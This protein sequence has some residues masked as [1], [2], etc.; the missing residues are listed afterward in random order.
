VKSV[1]A[2]RAALRRETLWVAA[3]AVLPLIPFLGKAF[4][5]DA[6]VFVAVARQVVEA[7]LDPFGFEMFWDETSLDVAEFNRNPPLL[8]YWLA[9]W[10]AAFGEREWVLRTAVLPFPLIA[11]LSFLGI[12]RRLC[13]PGL[14]PVV[15]LITGPAFVVLAT[16]LLLD[17][18]VLAAILFA[19]Y[20]LLRGAAVGEP[21]EGTLPGRQ[22]AAEGAPSSPGWYWAAGVAVAVAG[23]LKYVGLSAAPLLVAGVFLLCRRQPWAW[24]GVVVPPLCA[25]TAWGVASALLYGEVH[26]FGS[27]A[28]V[29]ERGVSMPQIGNQAVSTFVWYGAALG[30]PV[31]V[32]VRTLLRAG[33]GLEFALA[34]LA[35]GMLVVPFVMA[36]GE[37]ARRAP[38]ALG[39]ATFAV[40]AFAAGGFLWARLLLRWRPSQGPIDGFLVLWLAGFLC[41]AWFVNWH[42]NAADALLAAPPALLLLFRS[43]ELRLPT[44]WTAIGASAMLVLSL[45]LAAA[46]AIQANFYRAV[47]RSI[48][49][50]I[51]DRPG[52]RWFVGNW[53]FQHYLEREGFR[54]V[55]PLA[56][57]PLELAPGDWLAVPRNV[58]QLEIGEH[59]RRAEVVAEG[60]WERTSLLPLRTTNL[61]ATAG[62][63]SHRL[64]YTPF[65]WSF[66][67]V[68]QVQ[69]G[70]VTRIRRP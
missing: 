14:A 62:F 25:W 9:P 48:V 36:P 38:L 21:A 45:A 64:G 49:A 15:L 66:E 30:F 4:S 7:P 18:P 10:L 58:A 43:A 56:F 37:P 31:L 44:R 11:A 26:F 53:G 39:Q 65:G 19:V 20:C 35:V 5:V 1:P 60:R 40:L 63:Y 12:A 16:T 34:A 32:W 61:D 23:L 33:R 17:V 2:A 69:L 68:E 13:R 3:L 57:A 54:P 70:R 42:V 55:L 28:V 8:S 29:T 27:A 50:E 46:D 22:P 59:Q 47:A 67:P 41:F 52:A 6:P 24:A 51:G